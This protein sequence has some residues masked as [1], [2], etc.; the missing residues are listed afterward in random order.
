[1]ANRNQNFAANHADLVPASDPANTTGKPESIHDSARGTPEPAN[2]FDRLVQSINTILGP[3][4][5]IDSAGI[6]VEELKTAMRDY[7]SIEQE[8]EKFAFADYS[9]GYT[10]NLVDYGNGKSN[11][12]ILVWTPGKGSPIHDHANAHCVMRILKGRLTETLYTWPCQSGENGTAECATAGSDP[13]CPNT[14]HSCSKSMAGELEPASLDVQRATTYQSGEVAYM[15]D[16]LGLHRIANSS[17]DE[18]A[19]SLHLYTPPNAAKHGCHVFDE[20]TG[21][22]SHVKQ[23]HF[24]SELGVKN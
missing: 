11:L 1:M 20:K 5:G 4:N 21:K 2:A 3:C 13:S 10:R 9:R 22:K 6:D 16:N 24:Y 14:E 7:P 17:E 8:W 15:S 12:L 19:V 23:C 18:V